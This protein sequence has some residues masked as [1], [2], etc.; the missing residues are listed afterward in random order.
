M[1]GWC[2]TKKFWGPSFV[3]NDC[4]QELETGTF[5]ASP[6]FFQNWSMQCLKHDSWAPS[7]CVTIW[8]PDV[9]CHHHPPP[10]RGFPLHKMLEATRLHLDSSHGNW[11]VSTVVASHGSLPLPTS[12]PGLHFPEDWCPVTRWAI[13]HSFRWSSATWLWT[14]R[15]NSVGGILPLSSSLPALSFLPPALV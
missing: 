11:W 12:S 1:R 4:L 6:W 10:P 5:K 14:S 3:S 13:C 7:L 9:V 2:L 8:L 15:N